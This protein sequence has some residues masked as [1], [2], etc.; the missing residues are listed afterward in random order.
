MISLFKQ[1]DNYGVELLGFC[2]E[3]GLSNNDAAS[4]AFIFSWRSSFPYPSRPEAYSLNLLQSL[5][6][7]HQKFNLQLIC[8]RLSKS[9]QF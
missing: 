7:Q 8:H 1:L 3:F 6:H 5:G 4:V 2:V 9:S